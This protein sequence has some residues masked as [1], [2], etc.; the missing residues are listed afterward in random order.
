MAGG[1][2]PEYECSCS[3]DGPPRY[4]KLSDTGIWCSCMGRPQ[5]ELDAELLLKAFPWDVQQAA[6]T[7]ESTSWQA[8]NLTWVPVNSSEEGLYPP[9]GPKGVSGWTLSQPKATVTVH[10]VRFIFPAP[11]TRTPKTAVDA[12]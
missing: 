7:I 6:I 10:N 2:K 11:P 12:P 3:E 9:D 8:Q 1:D 4:T 5:L